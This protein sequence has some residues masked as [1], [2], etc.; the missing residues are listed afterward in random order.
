M[1]DEL[2]QDSNTNQLIF[3]V[4]DIVEYLS[5]A[6]TLE[7]GDVIFTGTPAGVAVATRPP[8]FLKQGD[9]VRVQIEGLGVLEN[10]VVEEPPGSQRLRFS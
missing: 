5:A 1:N 8:T 4:G 2:K 3:H 9:T 6:C 7:P 10:P